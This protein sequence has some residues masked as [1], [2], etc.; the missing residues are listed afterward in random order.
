MVYLIVICKP[1]CLKITLLWWYHLWIIQACLLWW[2]PFLQHVLWRC[3]NHLGILS[4]TVEILLFNLVFHDRV[5]PVSVSTL[6]PPLRVI[7]VLPLKP[8]ACQ[9]RRRWTLFIFIFSLLFLFYSPFLFL[10]QLRLGVISHAVT[11]VTTWW[12]SHKTDH[13][14]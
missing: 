4:S 3:C 6:K 5:T 14:T 11:S 13:G 12:R 7:G 1:T 9:D 2:P 8:R 10:E